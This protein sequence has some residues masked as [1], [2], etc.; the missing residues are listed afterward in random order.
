[1]GVTRRS[2]GIGAG[3]SVWAAFGSARPTAAAAPEGAFP[4]S[5]SDAEWRRRLSRAEYNVLR[6]SGT[7]RPYTSRLNGEKRAGRYSCA[8]CGQDAFSSATKYDSRT[9]WP[10]F[11]DVMPGAT[12]SSEDRSYGVIRTAIHCAQCGGHLGHVFDDGPAPTGKRYCINGVALRFRPG[13]T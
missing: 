11:Y 2:F 6:Q 12:G 5:L 9:G 4:V 3:L 10:S 7:E 8:G 1:M 13:S